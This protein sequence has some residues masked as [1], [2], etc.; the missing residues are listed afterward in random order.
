MNLN[1]SQLLISVFVTCILIGT[2]LLKLPI[3]TT[4]TITWIDSLFTATSAMTVT[5]LIVVDTPSAF[6]LFGEI[7]IVILIQLGGL[8]I[9]TFAVMIYIMLGRRI[10]IKGRL[11]IQQA[12]NQTSIGGVVKLVR[13]LFIFFLDHRD[14]SDDFF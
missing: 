13:N 4:E 3:A 9:M 10:G 14:N 12:L 7:I 5:G 2:L 6:T 1:P 11:V 8:G